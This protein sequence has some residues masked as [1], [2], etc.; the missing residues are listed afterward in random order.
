M[1]RELRALRSQLSRL[2]AIPFVAFPGG[3]IA[4]AQA[5]GTPVL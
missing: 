4:G 1:R 3:Q 5:W 2:A